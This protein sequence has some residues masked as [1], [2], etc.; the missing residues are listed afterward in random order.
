M[1][2]GVQNSIYNYYYYVNRL[3]PYTSHVQ[4]Q[5]YFHWFTSNGINFNTLPVNMFILLQIKILTTN[6]RLSV[7]VSS[8]TVVSP[9]D[10]PPGNF[11][12]QIGKK[13]EV[14]EKRS[15]NGKCRGKREKNGK[16]KEE[17]EKKLKKRKK[18]RR[19]I[20]NLELKVTEKSWL[21]LSYQPVTFKIFC[22]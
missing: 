13:N 7:M 20:R 9:R 6:C 17:N 4:T 1:F 16:G 2:F 19:K 5:I 8:L 21:I 12:W 18:E 11:W 15:K 22:R 10:F 3:K 14:K